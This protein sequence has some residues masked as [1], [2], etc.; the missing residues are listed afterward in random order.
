[1]REMEAQEIGHLVRHVAVGAT[2]KRAAM[3]LPQLDLEATIQPITRT[4][5]RVRLT[6][7]PNFKWNDRFHGKSQECFWIWVEDPASDHPSGAC[8]PEP[9][10]VHPLQPSADPDLP[11]ALPL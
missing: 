9:L 4:V 3:E 5:L 8:L 2:L 10:L 11:H 6:V 7:R 1:M